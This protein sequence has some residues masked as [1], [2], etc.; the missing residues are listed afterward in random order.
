MTGTDFNPNWGQSGHG[1]ANASFDLILNVVP[2][3]TNGTREI[4][5]IHFI[6]G[7]LHVD[8][9]V[10]GTFD[11]RVFVISSGTEIHILLLILVLNRGLV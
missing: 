2:G 4:Q 7:Y 1:S 9:W 11:P 5:Y 3:Y 6:N 8:I 10:D